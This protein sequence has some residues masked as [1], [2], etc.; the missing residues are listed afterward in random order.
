MLGRYLD[1]L[2]DEAR[3]RVR[4]AARWTT[5]DYA[6]ADG[7]CCLLGHA[8]DWYWDHELSAP[9]CRAR[10]LLE[11]RRLAG[12]DWLNWP[13]LIGRRFDHM[14]QRVGLAAAVSLIR[15]RASRRTGAGTPAVAA[16]L[17]SGPSL[18]PP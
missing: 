15:T 5:Q 10:Q 13:P 7:A 14:V 6:H 11:L 17:S 16:R 9:A 8:E 12:D 4:I 2:P 3:S 18:L 1:A